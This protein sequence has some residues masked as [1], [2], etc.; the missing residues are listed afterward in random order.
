MHIRNQ[1]WTCTD[2]KDSELHKCCISYGRRTFYCQHW[3]LWILIPSSDFRHKC[4][5]GVRVAGSP[6]PSVPR[7]GMNLQKSCWLSLH[8]LWV[9]SRSPLPSMSG[10]LSFQHFLQR[11]EM[12]TFTEILILVVSW[13][14][15]HIYPLVDIYIEFLT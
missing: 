15:I 13:L 5:I 9:L 12:W 2:L 1:N 14:W 7:C 3:C 6:M 8:L 10:S 11:F 4:C